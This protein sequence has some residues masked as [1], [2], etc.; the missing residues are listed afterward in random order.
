MRWRFMR[1][2]LIGIAALFCMLLGCG[3]DQKNADLDETNNRVSCTG[4]DSDQCYSLEYCEYLEECVDAPT[5]AECLAMT[6]EQCLAD[7]VCRPKYGQVMHDEKYCAI[8]T[9]FSCERRQTCTNSF[10]LM[11]RD[12]SHCAY[13]N[14]GCTPSVGTWTENGV[15]AEDCGLPAFLDPAFSVTCLDWEGSQ[16]QANIPTEPYLVFEPHFSVGTVEVGSTGRRPLQIV[17][18]GT[19]I[20]II[21]IEMAGDEF[22]VQTIELPFV[23]EQGES[24]VLDVS[25]TRTTAGPVSSTISITAQDSEF[26]YEVHVRA[27]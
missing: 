7:Q 12:D 23:I 13:F 24:L 17:N 14:N 22:S 10:T 11:Q 26:V 2:D 8:P 21:G 4:L 25:L 16:G 19:P 20:T 18:V 3:E 27:D 6:E 15:R 1:T 9:F 5:A